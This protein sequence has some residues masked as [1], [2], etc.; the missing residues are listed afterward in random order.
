MHIG[1]VILNYKTYL[2]TEKL[3][4]EI[5]AQKTIHK[6]YIQVVD[7][8]SP[9]ESAEYLS[10]NLSGIENVSFYA[11][12][13]NS[14]FAKG[15][16]VGLR[17]LKKHNVDYALI[18]NND[19]RFDLSVLDRLISV[20]D[21]VKD[22]G[23]IAPLQKL[24]NGELEVFE[25]LNCKNFLYDLSSFTYFIRKFRKKW[26]YKENTVYKNLQK[27]DIVPGCFLFIDYN[28][29]ENASFFDESTFLFWE[30]HFLY[31]KMEQAGKSN[32]LLLDCSY[33]H[34]H[35]KTINQEYVQ[36]GQFKLYRDGLIA[37]T[38]KYRSLPFI[39]CLL[40]NI[41]FNYTALRINI[42][43]LLKL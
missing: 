13:E 14:G 42:K 18:L 25:T 26:Q 28:L 23:V 43:K 22:A 10:K 8:A 15:N 32:Y 33:I 27:V 36:L 41:M 37:F 38:K 21:E 1:I 19:V 40:I 24:P 12:N 29:F 17:L 30:E 31:K 34:D 20:Y 4:K 5:V 9:N 7:N 2:D 35:S 16:N 3:V 39:K 11:N 6:L